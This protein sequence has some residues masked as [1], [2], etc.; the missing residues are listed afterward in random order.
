MESNTSSNFIPR[1][2]KEKYDN[3]EDRR[4]GYRLAQLQ[5]AKKPWTCDT[6]KKTILLGNKT[7]HLRFNKH[8]KLSSIIV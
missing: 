8:K 6:C 5:Y 4:E 7:K 3:E 1:K 2:Q